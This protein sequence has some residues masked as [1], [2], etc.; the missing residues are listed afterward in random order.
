MF[1]PVSVLCQWVYTD[2]NYVHA[3]FKQIF[4]FAAA[5]VV[6][7]VVVVVAGHSHKIQISINEIK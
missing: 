2:L 6:T 5:V 1:G 7:V 3:F 4:A